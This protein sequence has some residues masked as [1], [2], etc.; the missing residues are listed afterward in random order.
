MVVQGKNTDRHN[1]YDLNWNFQNFTFGFPNSL[2]REEK[3]KFLEELIRL[4]NILCQDF[5]FVRVDFFYANDKLYFG[6][7]TFTPRSGICKIRPK[8]YD[9]EIGN[10]LLL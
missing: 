3:P 5:K 6:E 2:K 7:M 9:R 10:L 8:E 4:S 1:V